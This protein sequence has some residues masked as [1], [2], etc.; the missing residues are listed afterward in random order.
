MAFEKGKSGNPGGKPKG[1]TPKGLFREQVNAALPSIVQSLIEAAQGGDVQAANIILSKVVPNLKPTSDP[2]RIQASQDASL[3]DRGLIV[4]H[5]ATTGKLSADDASQVMGLLVSQAKLIE[6]SEV[7]ERLEKIE[8][9]LS[10]G[11]P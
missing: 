4:V 10:E 9:W 2:V 5:A 8:Q 1:Q 3:A 11:K 6:Q 7:M